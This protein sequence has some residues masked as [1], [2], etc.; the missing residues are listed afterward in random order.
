MGLPVDGLSKLPPK[1]PLAAFKVTDK[2]SISPVPG[3][4][5][6][7]ALMEMELERVPEI[8]APK[9]SKPPFVN[10][11]TGDVGCGG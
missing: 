2:P 11:N 6:F 3:V 9:S 5:T 10:T 7:L 1:V 4:M 8:E